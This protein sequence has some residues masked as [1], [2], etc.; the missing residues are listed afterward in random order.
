MR[1]NTAKLQ[2]SLPIN[3]HN[4]EEEIFQSALNKFKELGVTSQPQSPE[5]AFEKPLFR[6]CLGSICEVESPEAEPI[7]TRNTTNDDRVKIKL[8][9]LHELL[10]TYR[11]ELDCAKEQILLGRAGFADW[12]RTALI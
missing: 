11:E 6:P 8:V 3:W 10:R 9:R 2:Q 7:R 1:S 4:E 12:L 5:P